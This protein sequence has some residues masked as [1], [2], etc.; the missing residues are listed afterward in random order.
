MTQTSYEAPPRN[1]L[2]CA[3]DTICVDD[4]A[5]TRW[6]R[7]VFNDKTTMSMHVGNHPEP[8]ATP[9]F[10]FRA[11]HPEVA[12]RIEGDISDLYPVKDAKRIRFSKSEDWLP[13]EYTF[14]NAVF[15]LN[16]AGN[17]FESSYNT[18]HAFNLPR[19]G[20]RYVHS[21]ITDAQGGGIFRDE[22]DVGRDTHWV[23]QS[24]AGKDRLI[25]RGSSQEFL[26]TDEFRRNSDITREVELNCPAAMR[27]LSIQPFEIAFNLHE[28]QDTDTRNGG[29]TVI[30]ALDP[31]DTGTATVTTDEH[32]V[33]PPTIQYG[34]SVDFGFK[35]GL[36]VP[37]APEDPL[38]GEVEVNAPDA[39][40]PVCM[41]YAARRAPGS[42]PGPGQ[43]RHQ[44][45][46]GLDW[47]RPKRDGFTAK[48][49]VPLSPGFDPDGAIVG[50][51]VGGESSFFK[52]DAKNKWAVYA[53]AGGG[54][55]GGAVLLQTG[56]RTLRVDAKKGEMIYTVKGANLAGQFYDDGL[57]N[58]DAKGKKVDVPVRVL[59]EGVVRDGIAAVTARSRT[60]KKLTAK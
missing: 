43:F 5:D 37:L 29:F 26:E 24:I 33:L 14:S 25:F 28:D 7:L 57:R 38:V 20:A 11:V 50:V 9:P 39:I 40:G 6:S 47:R 2:L 31:S 23:F 52:G 35:A 19:L 54:G 8:S 30:N 10:S 18:V 41:Y 53:G 12:R 36:S 49:D 59:A 3:T 46:V 17:G 16:A 48:L 13:S 60:D 27:R 15:N 1:A 21:Q 56:K 45:K 22:F 34:R 42:M 55:G 44:L 58:E 51:D 4:A 32:L